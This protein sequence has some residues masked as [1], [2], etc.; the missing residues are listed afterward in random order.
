MSISPERLA[1]ACK[2]YREQTNHQI[3]AHDIVL[4]EIL[5]A[6]DAFRA[7]NP[8]VPESEPEL[9]EGME[10][11]RD[12]YFLENGATTFGKWSSRDLRLIADH[13]DWRTHQAKPA[14]V[15]VVSDEMVKAFTNAYFGRSLELCHSTKLCVKDAI[16]AALMAKGKT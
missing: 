15:A 13:I 8:D 2:I 11:K 12:H 4:R 9:P 3:F 1:N 6:D 5:E 7:A 14:P 16:Q 10:F